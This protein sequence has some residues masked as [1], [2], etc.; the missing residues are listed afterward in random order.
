[1]FIR[2][3]Q[4]QFYL[5]FIIE[6]KCENINIKIKQWVQSCNNILP[7]YPQTSL[8]GHSGFFLISWLKYHLVRDVF[9]TFPNHIPIL[10]TNIIPSPFIAFLFI[11][12]RA[13]CVCLYLLGVCNFKNTIHWDLGLCRCIFNALYSSPN[14]AVL[15]ISTQQHLE[16]W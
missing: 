14:R 5:A 15:N 11:K 16:R 12:G 1:M 8:P 6:Y 4:R 9:L 3:Y 7:S 2:L 13:S 10:S